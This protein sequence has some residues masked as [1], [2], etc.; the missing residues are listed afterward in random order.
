[1][2]NAELGRMSDAVVGAT[3]LVFPV[4]SVTSGVGLLAE[5]GC[6]ML[7]EPREVTPGSWAAT[8]ADNGAAR[9]QTFRS[10]DNPHLTGLVISVNDMG[11]LQDMLESDDG[12]AAAKADGVRM[13]SLRVLR[14]AD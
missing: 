2:L 3:E 11:A 9:V 5:R 8:F 4:D 14:E 7:R 13:Q 6:G 12:I 10:V 1:M